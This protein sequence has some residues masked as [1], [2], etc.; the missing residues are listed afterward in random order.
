[1]GINYPV[2]RGSS[3]YSGIK[4]IIG[5]SNLKWYEEGG[6]SYGYTYFLDATLGSSSLGLGF[7]MRGDIHL[8]KNLDFFGG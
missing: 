5:Y 2:S 8:F 4:L 7:E 1:M 3:I 6:D